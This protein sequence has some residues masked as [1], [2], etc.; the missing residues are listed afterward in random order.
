MSLIKL[1]LI[2]LVVTTLTACSKTVQWEE[3]V[4]LNTGETIWVKRAVV[5][6]LQGAGGNPFDMA[7]RPDWTERMEFSWRSVDYIYEGAALVFVLAISPT[8]QPVLVARASDK[9]WELRNGYG[10]TKP[11]YVQLMPDATGQKWMWPSSIEPWLF[12]LTANLMLQR[13]KPEEM[14]NRYSFLDQA[15]EDSVVRAQTP[16]LAK[17]DSLFVINDCKGKI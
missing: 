12:G 4:P 9:N 10:C 2:G 1:V 17:V 5:Y 13:R 16:S 7:Y 15:S 14:K 11:S 6:K 8:E 3:E